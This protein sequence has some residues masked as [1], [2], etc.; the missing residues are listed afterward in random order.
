MK[1]GDLVMDDLDNDAQREP[2]CPTPSDPRAIRKIADDLE[3]FAQLES[4][5]GCKR[6]SETED[7]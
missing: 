4:K 6:A 3:D 1:I 2:N 5:A 7:Q